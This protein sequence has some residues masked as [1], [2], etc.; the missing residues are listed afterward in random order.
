MYQ[1]S[2][3][4]FITDKW[5]QNVDKWMKKKHFVHPFEK[6]L[7]FFFKLSGRCYIFSTSFDRV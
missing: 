4:P 2:V 6:F 3:K 1:Y 7:I 5:S